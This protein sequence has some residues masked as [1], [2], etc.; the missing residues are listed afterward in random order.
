MILPLL[1]GVLAVQG[2]GA[3]PAQPPPTARLQAPIDLTGYWVSVVTEDW[4]WRM[5][6]PPKGDYASLPLNAEGR[7]VADGW[8]PAGD[9]ASGNA[10]RAYGAAAIMRVPGRLH[11]TWQ[12]D[13]TLKIETDAGMQTRLLHFGAGQPPA[14]DA[15]WQGYSV[16]T[17][18]IAGVQRGAGGQRGD[19]PAE[20]AGRGRGA[21]PGPRFGSLKVVTTHLKSG[22]LR[23]NGVPY[24]ENAVVTEYFDRHTESNGAQWFT[25][26]TIVDDPKYLEQPFITSTHFKKEP[27][28]AKLRPM[29]CTAS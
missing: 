5:L 17:W 1:L 4:R 7:K 27:D 26:T 6:T 8:D 29:P 14:G 16:A 24:S 3:Q 10:C 23:K 25:V 12:D 2:S 13:V 9:E 18:E 22:Y 11:I 15:G 20:G 28:G 19:G 21:T